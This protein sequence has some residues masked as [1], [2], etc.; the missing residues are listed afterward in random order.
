MARRRQR[1]GRKPRSNP[2]PPERWIANRPAEIA[3]RQN[4]G[5]WKCNL[6]IFA[7]QFGRANVT[8]LQERQSRFHILLSNEER[9]SAPVIGRSAQALAPF[10]CPARKTITFDRKT[11]FFAHKAMTMGSY[12]CDPHSSWQKGGSQNANVNVHHP[13]GR[14]PPPHRMGK[15]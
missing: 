2:I 8:S 12:F 6:V 11:E 3:A 4:F 9:R 10:P 14:S 7:R 1:L 15:E 5:H 13:D